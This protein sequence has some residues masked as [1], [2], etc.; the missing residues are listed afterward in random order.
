M[1]ECANRSE[2]VEKCLNARAPP[3]PREGARAVRQPNE[4]RTSMARGKKIKVKPGKG[5][6]EEGLI[7]PLKK[8]H[9]GTAGMIDGIRNF[10]NKVPKAIRDVFPDI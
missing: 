9:D 3:V 6:F 8:S 1:R 7:Q 5:V 2:A 4:R 10:K